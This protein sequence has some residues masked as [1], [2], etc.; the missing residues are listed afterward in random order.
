M[1]QGWNVGTG[2]VTYDAFAL[3]P[4]VPLVDQLSCLDEDLLQVEFA[5]GYLIDLGWYPSFSPEGRFRLYVIKDYDWVMPVHQAECTSL[6]DL[7][8]LFTQAVQLV[9]ER[10]RL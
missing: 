1:R 2:T 10:I 3:D 6:T 7:K 9:E 5:G 8:A 4:T